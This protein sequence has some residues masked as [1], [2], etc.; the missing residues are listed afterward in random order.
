MFSGY[1][2]SDMPSLSD[3]RSFSIS[4]E[5]PTGSAGGGARAVPQE[6]SPAYHLGRGW[7][8]SPCINLAPHSRTIIAGYQGSGFI[9]HIWMTV[10]ESALRYLILRIYWD[11]TDVPAVETPLG[12]FFA[13]G[14]G[15]RCPINSIP[16]S[17][18]SSGGLNCYWCMPFFKEFK[19]EIENCLDKEVSGFFY[20]ISGNVGNLSGPPIYYHATYNR[21]VTEREKP[22]YRI[23]DSLNGYGVY[24]GC[25]LAWTQLSDGWWG[26]GEMKFYIDDD[27]DYPSICGTGTEDYFGGAW[28]FAD[29]TY[30]TPYLGYPLF[31]TSGAVPKHGLYRWHILDPI[32]FRKKMSVSIQ[33]IGWWPDGR[34]QPLADDIASVAHF[35]LDG[36]D[37]IGS[38]H[39]LLNELFPR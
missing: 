34:F 20:Q 10:D 21:S 4:A 36:P 33:A 13:N 39:L 16:V 2:I 28:G 29:G 37:G 27:Y 24:L 8:A 22:V 18:N 3:A 30:S 11:G 23:L 12:D 5:N 15:K 35:Y 38:K 17:V 25:Y 7:K 1:L 32:Y 19:I 14:H 9:Q 31:D 26:E 6:G